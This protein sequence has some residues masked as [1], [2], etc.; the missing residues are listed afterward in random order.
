MILRH[1]GTCPVCQG[2]W[3]VRSERLVHHGYVRPGTGEIF[4]DCFGVNRPPHELSPA[5]AE[6]YL[7]LVVVP[8][9]R[10]ADQY[11]ESL[12]PPKEPAELPFNEW[13]R[14][15]RQHTPV[16]RRRED[17]SQYDWGQRL[18]SERRSAAMRLDALREEA[19]RLDGLI[20]SWQ[21]KP[22]STVEEMERTERE[23]K[24][25]QQSRVSSDREQRSAHALL[26]LQQRIDR[27][28][29]KRDAGELTELFTRGPYKVLEPLGRGASLTRDD[30]LRL[31]DRD[32]VWAALGFMR[33]QDYAA[34]RDVP[35]WLDMVHRTDFVWPAAREVPRAAV[36]QVKAEREAKKQAKLQQSVDA[37]VA[38]FSERLDRALRMRDTK[39][40][41]SVFHRAE[42]P[43]EIARKL[44][45]RGRSEMLRLLGRD[46]IWDAF[47]WMRPDGSY[48]AAEDLEELF[49]DSWDWGPETV[50]W[51]RALR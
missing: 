6:A 21:L 11:V 17:V 23:T 44:P 7:R 29:K 32:E 12:G 30:V 8:E 51:P 22:L 49:G 27:A 1:V 10:A 38:S 36:A 15:M 42:M 40:I 14:E 13:N 24:S 26:N 48:Y 28:V 43:Y 45:E 31:A 35:D 47:G 20:T 50:P 16:L 9:L 39:T 18:D 46:E 3:K 41:L 34:G 33:G 37:A 19:A 4:G 25:A 5:T 2:V